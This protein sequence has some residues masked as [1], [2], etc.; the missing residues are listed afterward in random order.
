MSNFVRGSSD[1][2]SADLKSVVYLI[3]RLK[4]VFSICYELLRSF[5]SELFLSGSEKRFRSWFVIGVNF[6]YGLSA[7]LGWSHG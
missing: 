5:C 7:D 6:F 4:I 1:S 2:K 3:A